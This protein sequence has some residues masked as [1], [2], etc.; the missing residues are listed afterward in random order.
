M[1]FLT[2]FPKEQLVNNLQNGL[3]ILLLG[4]G[5]VF[6]FL[7]LL[8]YLTKWMSSIVRKFEP[9]QKP[10]PKPVVVETVSAPAS[11]DAEVAAAICAAMKSSGGNYAT[12]TAQA[13]SAPASA[14]KAETI[15]SAPMPGLIL[16]INVKAGQTVKKNEC[17]IVMEAMKMENEIYSPVDGTVSKISVALQQ[18]MQSGDVLMTIA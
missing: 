14:P 10:Q 13:A 12:T 11:N 9:E 7:T 4:M 3:I 16:K 1:L 17:I 6:V 5:T 18:Q 8:V 15:V 2:Q